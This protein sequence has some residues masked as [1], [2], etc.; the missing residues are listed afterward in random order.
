MNNLIIGYGEIRKAVADL[1]M[2]FY[3]VEVY[4][5][6]QGQKTLPTLINVLHICFP[7]SETFVEDVQK[8]IR[9][10]RPTHVIVWSSTPIGTC[11]KIGPKTIHSP[12]EGKHPQLAKSIH[13]MKRWVGSDDQDEAAWAVGYFE[14]LGITSTVANHSSTT[15]ALKLLSTTEYGINLVF[16]DY[17]KHVA[18][19]LDIPYDLMKQWN[20]DYNQLYQ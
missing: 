10:T 14:E 15:E 5:I 7:P 17:K 9:L 2:P 19:S 3:Q 12:V 6:A 4:D 13:L 1:L 16:T 20:T 8:Y 18:D 11:S